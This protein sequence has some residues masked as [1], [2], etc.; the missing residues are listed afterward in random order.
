MIFI[1]KNSPSILEKIL[2][3]YNVLYEKLTN[4]DFTKVVP[5]ENLGLDPKIVAQCS[6]STVKYLF[7]VLDY[8]KINENDKILDIGCGKGYAIKFFKSLRYK[9]V[10]GLEISKLLTTIA[11]N[12][13][14]KININSKIFNINA[15]KF[16]FYGKYDIFYLYNPFPEKIAEHVFFNIKEQIK[17]FNRRFYIIYA[18]PV[19]HKKLIKNGFVLK[20][21]FPYIGSGKISVYSYN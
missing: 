3:R 12:N 17:I 14:K 19:A 15:T 10:H 9:T 7:K 6:P 8:L 5:P 13:F 4:V 16:K 11:R 21:N 2:F 18:N 20:K 1:K